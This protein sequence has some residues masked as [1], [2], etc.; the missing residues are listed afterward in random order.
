MSDIRI[1]GIRHHGP[2]SARS[3]VAALADFRPDAVLIEGPPDAM[4]VLP[5]AAHP[6]MRPP[7]ALLVYAVDTPRLASFAPLAEFSPEWQAIQYAHGAGVP[8]RFID[9]PMTHQLA[10]ALSDAKA[11]GTPD[12]DDSSDGQTGDATEESGSASDEDRSGGFELPLDGKVNA[13]PDPRRDPFGA[14]ALAAGFIDGERLWDRLVEERVDHNDVFAAIQELMTAL[15]EQSDEQ[16]ALDGAREAHMRREIDRARREGF[17]RIAVVCGAWHVPALAGAP[18]TKDDAAALKRLPAVKVAATWT[19]WTYQRLTRASG[20]GAGVQSPAWY[21]H[22]WTGHE[23]SSTHW[24]ARAAHLLRGEGL[25]A[26]PAQV[27]DA[28]RLAETLA[29]VRGRSQPGLDELREAARTV[30]CFDSNAPMRLIERLLL[31]GEALGEVPEETPAA[32]LVADFQRQV[33]RLRLPLTELSETRELDLRQESDQ[34]RGLLLR[35][36]LLLDVP[37]GRVERTGEGKGT[38]RER[39]TL[40]WQP[41]FHVRLIEAGVW[42]STLDQAAAGR[43]MQ[44]AREASTLGDLTALLESCLLAGVDGAREFVLGRLAAETVTTTDLPPL[45]TAVPPLVRISRYGDVRGRDQTTVDGLLGHLLNRI[46]IA[47]PQACSGMDE[48]AARAF[49]HLVTEVDKALITLE[50]LERRNT[51]GAALQRTLDHAH[52]Q[53]LLGG[54]CAR[55]LLLAGRLTAGDVARRLDR[56]LSNGAEP[57]DGAGW[58]EGLLTGGGQ[59]VVHHD[60]LFVALDGWLCALRSDEFERVLPLIRRTFAT[61]ASP[62]RRLIGD[63]VQGNGPAVRSITLDE[64]RGDRTLPLLGLLLG[65][66]SPDVAATAASSLVEGAG[67]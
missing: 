37:W 7:V 52:V 60:A 40:Q 39:W 20:Y 42:G 67:Q 18:F 46:I 34:A 66:P 14:L 35:R 55:L 2:G 11:T 50:D 53:P 30:F 9:L 15:R 57:E 25:D 43:A 58:I 41:E 59:L 65:I 48:E 62:E 63:R 16:T 17:A 22:L 47:L 49:A 19:P 13:V 27:L 8:A 5:L 4:A 64:A 61:F 1:Y 23:H 38:F 31:V 6:R 51:W 28:S 10:A 21:A 29:I 24:L 54:L 44:L 26:S 33:K 45:L 12:E 3:L 56:S 36:L 32:P